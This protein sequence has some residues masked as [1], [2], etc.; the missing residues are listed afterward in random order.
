[1]FHLA[2]D[3]SMYTEN[4]QNIYTPSSYFLRTMPKQHNSQPEK[5]YTQISVSDMERL[6]R[7][8][9]LK[10]KLERKEIESP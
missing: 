2:I 7:Q 1:L 9:R 3:L 5:Y 8:F 10:R 4:K 6:R